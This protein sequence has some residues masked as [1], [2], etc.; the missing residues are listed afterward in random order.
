MCFSCISF[1]M[2][3]TKLFSIIFPI[4]LSQWFLLLPFIFVFLHRFE[5]S[6]LLIHFRLRSFLVRRFAFMLK[7]HNHCMIT[8]AIFVYFS[9][10]NLCDSL[11]FVAQWKVTTRECVSLC[12][13]KQQ[14]PISGKYYIYIKIHSSHWNYIPM[15]KA[16]S[17]C[18]R[19]GATE[20]LTKTP[21][22][23]CSCIIIVY[24]LSFSAK[25]SALFNRLKYV[26]IFFG[27]EILALALLDL[28]RILCAPLLEK[29]PHQIT[30]NTENT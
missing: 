10:L 24:R 19:N 3:D 18:S 9:E 8:C 29:W 21:Y 20:S 1:E 23:F 22:Y 6:H 5:C 16:D 13:D 26:Y 11:H 4:G 15:R 2:R 12:R 27:G 28:A 14:T 30:A 7:C 25:P 17:L